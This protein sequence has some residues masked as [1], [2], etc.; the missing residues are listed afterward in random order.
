MDCATFHHMLIACNLV[1]FLIHSTVA[2]KGKNALGNCARSLRHS[3]HSILL[4][5]S[6]DFM[7]GLDKVSPSIML[8]ELAK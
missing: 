6:H 8:G 4:P 5:P 7:Q 3:Q 1:I 2:T